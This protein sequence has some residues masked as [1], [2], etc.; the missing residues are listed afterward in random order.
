VSQKE[1]EK[2]EKERKKEN[3][4]TRREPTTGQRRRKGMALH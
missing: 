2:R 4:N 1:R 3:R